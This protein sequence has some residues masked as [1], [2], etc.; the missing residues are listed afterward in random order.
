MTGS[1]AYVFLFPNR[2]SI[3]RRFEGLEPDDRKLSRPVL[4]GPGLSNGVRPLGSPSSR[5]AP[6]DSGPLWFARPLTYATFIHYT[7]PV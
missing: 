4:R 3:R 6:H 2:V 5:A 1:T 7:L